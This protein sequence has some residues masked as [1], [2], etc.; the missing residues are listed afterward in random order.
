MKK[1]WIFISLIQKHHHI[2]PSEWNHC[3]NQEDRIRTNSS[4]A[5]AQLSIL[6]F[7]ICG[8]R[9]QPPKVADSL[10][11]TLSCF[12]WKVPEKTILRNICVRAF[13]LVGNKGWDATLC[14]TGHNPHVGHGWRTW[15][16][17]ERVPGTPYS[18]VPESTVRRSR[19]PA[20]YLSLCNSSFYFSQH[21]CQMQPERKYRPLKFL[22]LILTCH[23]YPTP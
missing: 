2:F 4:L 22:H 20:G 15:P 17:A 6:L 11:N 5:A 19:D 16:S 3:S 7:L 23:S 8:L 14:G 10:L 13:W 18:S 1:D 12:S 9:N 21:P